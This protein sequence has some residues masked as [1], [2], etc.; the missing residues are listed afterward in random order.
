MSI[1]DIA[2]DALKEI[3]MADVLR[4]RLSLAF[5]YSAQQESK[6][7]VLQTEKADFK[8]RLEIERVNHQ[9]TQ[10]ELERLRKEHEEA[11]R[12]FH[13]IEFRRGKRTGNE[14]VAFCPKCHLPAS[15]Q[16]SETLMCSDYNC[17]WTSDVETGNLSNII[18][19]LP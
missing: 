13:A 3:P 15:L 17:S 7:E 6:I 18:K 1:I 2:R 8:A 11:V 10:Q 9:K 5:D 4:E 12:I 14:W 16:R 19:Q